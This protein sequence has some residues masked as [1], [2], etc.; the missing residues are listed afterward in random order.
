MDTIEFIHLQPSDEIEIIINGIPLL[1]YVANIEQYLID[2]HDPY[3]KAGDHI[4]IQTY[5]FE[6]LNSQRGYLACYDQLPLLRCCSVCGNPSIITHMTVTHELVIWHNFDQL[7]NNYRPYPWVYNGLGPFT[8]DRQ[9]YTMAWQQAAQSSLT[10]EIEA[11]LFYD[12]GYYGWALRIKDNHAALPSA[13]QAISLDY[14]NTTGEFRCFDRYREHRWRLDFMREYLYLAREGS[15]HYE[16]I[17]FAQDSTIFAQWFGAKLNDY[18]LLW[19]KPQLH[20]RFANGSLWQMAQTHII[21]LPIGLT[22]LVPQ[23]S[24]NLVEAIDLTIERYQRLLQ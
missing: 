17:L 6:Q 4:N 11:E 23:Q 19:Q 22:V 16:R 5:H 9:Q 24:Y 12:G 20:A 7:H 13:G 2:P 14:A 10:D 1:T 8:F 18:A 3:Q 21:T 15:S